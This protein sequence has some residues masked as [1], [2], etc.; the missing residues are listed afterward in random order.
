MFSARQR[1][2]SVI[3][4]SQGDRPMAVRPVDR[5]CH[6]F[7][8]ETIIDDEPAHDKVEEPVMAR[9]RLKTSNGIGH[10]LICLVST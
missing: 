9:G 2:I 1:M 10:F 8:T 7:G 3:E 5:R 6:L 4:W